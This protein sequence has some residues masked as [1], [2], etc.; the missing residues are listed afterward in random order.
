MKNTHKI[1]TVAD[2]IGDDQQASLWTEL[3]DNMTSTIRGGKII[4]DSKG[5]RLD[6]HQSSLGGSVSQ[7][8][9]TGSLPEYDVV[10][11]QGY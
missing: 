7:Y 6:F 9:N 2:T 5:N 8:T 3:S 10:F 11:D 1:S 4:R